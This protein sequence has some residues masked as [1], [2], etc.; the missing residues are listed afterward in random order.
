M[1]II[2]IALQIVAMYLCLFILLDMYFQSVYHLPKEV[3]IGDPP[4]RSAE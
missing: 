1:R 4:S 3:C 2:L